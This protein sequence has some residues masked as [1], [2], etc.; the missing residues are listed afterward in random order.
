MKTNKIR[1][2]CLLLAIVLCQSVNAQTRIKKYFSLHDRNTNMHSQKNVIPTH[3][4][5]AISGYYFEGF[6]NTFPPI[7]WQIVDVLDTTSGWNSSIAADYPDAFE[8]LQSAH[9]QYSP[10]GPDGED[11]FIAPKFTVT[12]GDSISFYF[13]FQYLGYPPDSTFILISNTDSALTSFIDELDFI[14]DTITI[15]GTVLPLWSYKSYSL[16]DYA[17]Q[18]IYIAFKN[19]NTLGDGVFIDNLEI[20]TRP[21]A[22]VSAKS[23]DMDSF[24]PSGISNPKASVKNTGGSTQTFDVTMMITGGYSSTKSITVPPQ[25]TSQI[26]FDPWSAVVGNYIINIQTLLA[27]DANPANDTLSSSIKVLEPFTNYGW[28]IHDPL[29]TPTLGGS[30]VSVCS[31]T[32]SR[33]FVLGG[34]DAAFLTDAYEYDLS[35]GTWSGISPLPVPSGYAGSAHANDKI[36]LFSGGSL[37]NGNPNGATQIYD[38]ITDTWTTGSPMP[39]PSANFATGIYKDSLV[40]FVGGNIGN[41]V[42]TNNVQIYNTYTDV[43]STGST[44]PGDAVYAIRGGI[45]GNKMVI[46][47][48]Y[49]PITAEAIGTTYIG[50]IDTLNPTQI[51]WTQVADHPSGKISRQGACVSLDNNSSLVVFTGGTNTNSTANTT[52]K[53]FAYDVNSNNWKLGPDKPTALNLFYMTPVIENDSIYIAALGGGD[54]NFASDK[55]EWLNLGYYQIPTS[56]TESKAIAEVNLFPNPT[57]DLS[58]LSVKL[59]KSTTIKI[60]ITDLIGNII[61]NVCDKKFSAGKNTISISTDN[62]SM[63]MYFVSINTEGKT[64][65]KKLIKN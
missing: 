7:G 8:G 26:V 56:I 46:S 9:C 37:S 22:E 4:A 43:W 6:E 54:G 2:C 18:D 49:N 27:N 57:V 53:T 19:K 63:G 40:Y 39:V 65:I 42:A 17:G 15:P 52:N 32:N 30:A 16:N 44:K 23:I 34:L 5:S 48:G 29:P 11:W 14:A 24:Y 20:G 62:L 1:N 41:V 38:Y 3:L 28:S 61:L 33:Y 21:A 45:S 31:T 25:V 12:T 10:A 51:S 13:K 35:F 60:I 59:N 58:T 36:F 50:E 47:G 64:I 55:N